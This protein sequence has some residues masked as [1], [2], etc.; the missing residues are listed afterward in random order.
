VNEHDSANSQPSSN[1]GAFEKAAGDAI[2]DRIEAIALEIRS[3]S[4]AEEDILASNETLGALAF[5]L[6]KILRR[7]D[8]IF[9]FEGFAASPACSLMLELFQARVRGDPILVD[10]L[11]QSMNCSASVA[12]RWIDAL[13]SMQLVEKLRSDSEAHK[14]VLSRKGYLKTAQALHLL[15]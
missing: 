8:E 14:V 15:R 1:Q 6:Q 9:E 3:V 11:C 7:I 10:T 13:E 2:A 12:S 5:T 4:G